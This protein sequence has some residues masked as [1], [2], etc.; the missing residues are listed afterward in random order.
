MSAVS[1]QSYE[2]FFIYAIPVYYS[3]KPNKTWVDF[4]VNDWFQNFHNWK[5]LSSVVLWDLKLSR[6]QKRIIAQANSSILMVNSWMGSVSSSSYLNIL[7]NILVNV[8]GR[9]YFQTSVILVKFL[10]FEEDY[11]QLMII[12]WR[13]IKENV[14]ARSSHWTVSSL[15]CC[16]FCKPAFNSWRCKNKNVSNSRAL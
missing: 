13:Y 3:P 4:Q 2:S 7:N 10:P 14:K 12:Y 6:D 16:F 5:L 1:I 8:L 15:F 11:W 9:L